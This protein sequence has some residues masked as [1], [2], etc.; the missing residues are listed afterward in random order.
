METPF[1]APP[2]PGQAVPVAPGIFWLRMPLPFALDH[3][4]LWLIE[5]GDGWAVI[6]T[7]LPDR[8]T[9][10]LWDEV[11]AGPMAGRAPARLVVTHFHPDHMGLAAWLGRRFALTMEATL[12][13]WLYGRML[14]LDP[15]D[16]FIEASRGFYRAAGFDEALMTVMVERGNAYGKR[17]REIPPALRRLRGGEE[18]RIGGHRW[19]VIVGRGHSPEHACL[20]CEE[21]QV[22]IS[23]DQILPTI[24][25]NVSVW[26]N[27][28]EANPL[29]DFLDSLQVFRPLPADVLVL[30]SH[31]LPFRGLHARLDALEQHHDERL[32]KTLDACGTPLSALDVLRVLFRRELDTHQL[33]FAL[34]ES[35]SHLHCLLH[36]G[37]L[38]C[39]T[40]T[41]GVRRFLRC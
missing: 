40:D 26:P 3:V 13:E 33:F 15:G 5:D 32:A 2:P 41:A 1:P 34:G 17:V 14:S 21:L 31:G 24:S 25:P 35:L 11:L 10:E 18:I 20:W 7:G 4:N 29:Q 22:L 8:K 27:E 12:A 39:E 37:K 16:G 28:P 36:Q 30:P 23:G 19:R 6:D 38:R 9:R